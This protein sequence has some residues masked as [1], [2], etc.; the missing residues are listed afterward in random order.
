MQP[1][2]SGRQRL[3]GRSRSAA[4]GRHLGCRHRGH[5]NLFDPPGA[6]DPAS[7][8]RAVVRG[9]FGEIRWGCGTPPS[10]RADE[11]WAFAS[12]RIFAWDRPS[13]RVELALLRA[14]PDLPPGMHVHDAW[15]GCWRLRG[16]TDAVPPELTCWVASGIDRLDGGPDNGE[17]LDA[18]TWENRQHRVSIGT[19][20]SDALAARAGRDVPE[21]WRSELLGW[22][23][24]KATRDMTYPV[25]HTGD[26]LA[27]C[28]PEIPAG[29]VCQSHHAAAWQAVDLG[30]DVSTWYAVEL[31][32]RAA[33]SPR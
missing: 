19:E 16:D 29:M 5:R 3:A 13:F 27:L 23:D 7:D 28:L 32:R 22:L 14:V 21:R 1:T 31:I 33:P 25:L 24:G 4:P 6:L 12:G 9:D 26:G 20:D 30:S 10:G 15:I 17:A 18:Q 11:A 2:S 8:R